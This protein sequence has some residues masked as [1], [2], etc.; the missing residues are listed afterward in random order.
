M[1]RA[2]DAITPL[3]TDIEEDFQIA[4]LFLAEAANRVFRFL[5]KATGNHNYLYWIYGMLTAWDSS[6][7]MLDLD[8][9]VNENH[10]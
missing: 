3:L 8:E 1:I 7:G 4:Y 2:E 10:E 9:Y 5:Q 6:I